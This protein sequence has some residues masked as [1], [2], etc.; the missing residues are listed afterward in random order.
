[1]ETIYGQGRDTERKRL[2][3]GCEPTTTAA[4]VIF[5][6]SLGRKVAITSRRSERV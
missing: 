1:M 2:N 4:Q 3:T 5:G 6:V